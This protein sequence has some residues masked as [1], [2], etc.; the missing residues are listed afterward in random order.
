MAGL[1]GR[2]QDGAGRLGP[3]S[4]RPSPL[5]VMRRLLGFLFPVK[6]WVALSVLLGAL[7]VAS[8]IGLL[9][10]SAW[11]ISAAAL[12]PS[13]AELSVAIVGVRFFGI[14]RGVFRYLERLSS[15]NTT[16]RLLAQLRVWFYRSLEPLAPARLQEARSGDL[17]GRIISDVDALEDFYVRAVAPPLVAVVVGSAM[18]LFLAGFALRLALVLASFL[19]LAGL[20]LP[21]LVVRLS[22]RPG[23]QI[24]DQRAALQTNLVDALVGMADLQAYGQAGRMM[25]QIE[26]GSRRLAELERRMARI[27]GLHSG[28]SLLLANLALWSVLAL[29][30][31]LVEQGRLA[32]LNLA[33]LA[34]ATL[35]TFEAVQPLPV[36]AQQL[37]T[38]LQAAGRLFHFLDASPALSDPPAPAV[39]SGPPSLSVQG[40][41]FRYGPR[42]PWALDGLSFDLPA[43]RRLAIV[44]PS[45]AGKSTLANILLRF[46]DFQE[47]RVVLAGRPIGDYGQADV[48]GL[49]GFVAQDSHIFNAPIGD[50]IRIAHPPAG[51]EEIVA[52]A[53]QAQL[54]DF[55]ASLP[56]GYETGVGQLGMQLSGGQRQRLVIAR[57]AV[58]RPP[59]L[60][61]D[62]P[63]ANLDPLTEAGVLATL[64]ALAKG[65]SLLLITHRLVALE[66]MDE[67]LVLDAGRVAER[68]T[69]TE[70][71]SQA[72][73]YRRLW[74]LQHRPLAPRP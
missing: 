62:E 67:I 45:G 9:A 21:L 24:V 72:G 47:G 29:A 35:A 32:G 3:P 26:A 33:A 22:R 71:M 30:I 23:R 11:L 13:I 68:G 69:H 74:D 4:S 36:A 54:D 66:Q 46:W 73:L 38:S 16:F 1:E 52:A 18:F 5:A 58:R 70:L 40:L 25:A 20:A 56:E 60:L 51:P 41:R 59:I 34:L 37:A 48:R 17:L 7:T 43:G 14:S 65:R 63:T 12:Q 8:G 19:A 28:L 2:T 15:H 49:F 64:L 55:V 10:T 39:L 57:A 53:R 44:G 27:G 61:L 42:E 31:P 50:N 6:G